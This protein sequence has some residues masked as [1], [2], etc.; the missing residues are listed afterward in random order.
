MMKIGFILTISLMLLQ[1]IYA[2][3]IIGNGNIE[4]INGTSIKDINCQNYTIKSGGLLDTSSGG[5]LREVTKFEI[6]GEWNYGEGQIKELGSWVNNG[7]VNIQPTQLGVDFNLEFTTM[8]GPISVRGTSDTDGDG[9]SDANE[10][11][12][13]VNLGHGITLDQ[14][15][16]GIY[17]FLDNDSD[18]DGIKD[19]EEGGN[20]IDFDSDGIPDYLD[21][22][23]RGIISGTITEKLS[24]GQFIAMEGIVII[25]YDMD[26]NEVARTDTDRDGLYSFI[27]PPGEYYIQELQPEGY[28]SLQND[29]RIDL[30]IGANDVLDSNDFIESLV[31]PQPTNTPTATPSPTAIVI[32]KPTATVTLTPTVTA[33][34]TA[35]ATA[36][37]VVEE[38]RCEDVSTSPI[39]QNDETSASVGEVK[40][41]NVLKNDTQSEMDLDKKSVRLIDTEGKEVKTLYSKGKGTWLVDEVTGSILFDP[42]EVCSGN[43]EVQYIVRDICGNTSNPATINIDFNKK[44]ESTQTS[45]SANALSKSTML[46]LLLCT[47]AIG[48]FFVRRREYN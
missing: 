38:M 16:D 33:T 26:G 43:E 34:P 39:A 42:D 30:T 8:C 4:R 25:L 29:D 47:G 9:I 13:A 46:L 27:I 2:D 40:T 35:T 32:V 36:M 28:F 12:N 17:N 41:I 31:S 22:E 1:S 45:D 48:L 37:P 23:D 20:T 44:C 19:S 15:R 18:N 21:S 3:V 14:D 5:T 11:D 6:H 10:G 7:T 24:N